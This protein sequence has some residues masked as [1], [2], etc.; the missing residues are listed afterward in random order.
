MQSESFQRPEHEVIVAAHACFSATSSYAELLGSAESVLRGDAQR[1]ALACIVDPRARRKLASDLMQRDACEGISHG[2]LARFDAAS[3]RPDECVRQFDFIPEAGFGNGELAVRCRCG[4]LPSEHAE[5]YA[6]MTG[7]YIPFC[8]HD[9]L[10]SRMLSEDLRRKRYRAVS[11]FHA[12]MYAAVL[13]AHAVGPAVRSRAAWDVLNAVDGGERIVGPLARFLRIGRRAAKAYCAPDERMSY[14]QTR[15]VLRVLHAVPA[16]F[17]FNKSDDRRIWLPIVDLVGRAAGIEPARLFRTMQNSFHDLDRLLD[18]LSAWQKR[19]QLR[20]AIRFLRRNPKGGPSMLLSGLLSILS[21]YP[22][23]EPEPS[24]RIELDL[25]CGWHARALLTRAEI[26]L[27]FNEMGQYVGQYVPQVLKGE[28]QVF[29]LRSANG[30]D[31]MTAVFWPP[32]VPEQENGAVFVRA[33]CSECPWIDPA[34]LLALGELLRHMRVGMLM[35]D[36]GV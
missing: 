2:W 22:D 12:A 25:P 10:E 28:A 19:Q 35:I 20:S 30:E 7:Y 9:Y 21:R 16:A 3:T 33:S 26:C 29:A 36:T 8:W 27:H 5:K 1:G 24:S 18:L 32:L 23:P 34:G 31:R 13:A 15:R 11:R 6:G 4:L 14:G 17:P